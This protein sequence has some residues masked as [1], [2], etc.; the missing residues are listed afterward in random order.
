[1]EV[2]SDQNCNENCEIVKQEFTFTFLFI[3]NFFEEIA[4]KT[5]GYFFE[6]FKNGSSNLLFFINIHLMSSRES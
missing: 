5:E 1:M 4:I 6:K 2:N 3:V